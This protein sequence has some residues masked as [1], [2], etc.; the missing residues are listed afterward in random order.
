MVLTD[1]FVMLVFDGLV[2]RRLERTV[3]T[4]PIVVTAGA[5]Y[6]LDGAV[7]ERVGD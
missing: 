1:V 7:A 4:A 3:L 5:S 2:S 6:L